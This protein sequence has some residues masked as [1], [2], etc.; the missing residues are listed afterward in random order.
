MVFE[1]DSLPRRVA[2]AYAAI[3][4]PAACKKKATYNMRVSGTERHD[5]SSGE[6]RISRRRAVL[7]GLIGVAILVGVYLYFQY[8]RVLAPLVS[9]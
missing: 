4:S 6:Q 9:S 2:R 3:R 7:W 1:K 8:E 5:E